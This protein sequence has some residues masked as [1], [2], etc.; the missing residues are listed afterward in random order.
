[1]K[2]E[3]TNESAKVKPWVKELIVRLLSL[4]LEMIDKYLE[5]Y[6]EKAQVYNLIGTA[7]TAKAFTYQYHS[8]KDQELSRLDSELDSANTFLQEFE[9]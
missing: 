7:F 5:T 2:K 1:M 8:I 3:T 6:E 9:K 4:A